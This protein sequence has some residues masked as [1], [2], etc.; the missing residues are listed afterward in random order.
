MFTGSIRY[1]DYLLKVVS[2]DRIGNSLDLPY[3]FVL[4]HG[5]KVGI[6]ADKVI[7]AVLRLIFV[8]ASGVAVA[9]DVVCYIFT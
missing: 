7:L 8:I 1:V 5:L 4:H 3:G 6:N 9:I 2:S